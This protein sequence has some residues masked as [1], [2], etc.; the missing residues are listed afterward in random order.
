[1]IAPENSEKTDIALFHPLSMQ[2]LQ[3]MNVLMEQCIVYRKNLGL[4][5]MYY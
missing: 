1:M 3:C 4:H 2:K 5:R